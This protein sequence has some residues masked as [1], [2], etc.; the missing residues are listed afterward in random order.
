MQQAEQPVV[1]PE[2]QDGWLGLLLLK[3]SLLVVMSVA[4]VL[5][6][7]WGFLAA[8]AFAAWYFFWPR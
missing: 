7:G 4:L 5:F 6:A 2:R 3:I 1:E 8:P